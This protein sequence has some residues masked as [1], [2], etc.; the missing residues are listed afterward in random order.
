[1]W[2]KSRI[3]QAAVILC[4]AMCICGCGSG[5]EAESASNKNSAAGAQG[6]E[7][8]TPGKESQNNDVEQSNTE[9][10][11]NDGYYYMANGVT[12]GVDMDMDALL[13]ELGESKSVFEAPS[14]AGE[15]I[16]YFYNYGSYEIE[17]YPAVDGKN[18][19]GYITLKDDTTATMEGVDLSMTKDDVLRI[20]GEDYEEAGEGI[21]YEKGDTKLRFIFDGEDITSIEYVSTVLG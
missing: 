14:C 11:G 15:G 2:K 8:D 7:N 13:P 16:S 18:R 12:V 5:N 9:Q 1:M 4:M 3:L 20:Y 19:I 10:T 6:A 21:A 17:T